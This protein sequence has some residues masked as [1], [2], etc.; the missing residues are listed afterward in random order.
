[1][2]PFLIQHSGIIRV[3]ERLRLL[4][5]QNQSLLGK[6]RARAIY[7]SK[8]VTSVESD[9]HKQYGPF[10][11]YWDEWLIQAEEM[12]EELNESITST[13]FFLEELREFIIALE[14][15]KKLSRSDTSYLVEVTSLTEGKVTEQLELLE[16]INAEIDLHRQLTEKLRLV[17]A[18]DSLSDE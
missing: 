14:E 1:M 4:L 2:H 13:A 10:A 12:K 5:I 11:G 18:I 17:E 16:N 8:A 6:L 3:M 7:C 15:K 9:T